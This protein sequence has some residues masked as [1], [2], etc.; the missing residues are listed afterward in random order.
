MGER[1]PVSLLARLGKEKEGGGNATQARLEIK[2]QRS[3]GK[4]LWF[5]RIA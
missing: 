4:A 5:G 2:P 1:K 3:V